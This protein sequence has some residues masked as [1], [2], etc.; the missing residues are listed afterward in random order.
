MS[1]VSVR[2]ED[3][4]V[5]LHEVRD[6]VRPLDVLRPVIN[7]GR[8]EN[9][10]WARRQTSRD[11]RDN[12]WVRDCVGESCWARMFSMLQCS[13]TASRESNQGGWYN[14]KGRRNTTIKIWD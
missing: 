11:L 14:R 4:R 12:Q 5:P 9:E 3:A 7:T 1:L 2:S 13:Q 6:R 10:A 8:A